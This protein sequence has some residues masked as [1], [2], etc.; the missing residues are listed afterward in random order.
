MT[1]SSPAL[2]VRTIPRAATAIGVT[3]LLALGAT[4][5]RP[6]PS[7]AASGVC[8]VDYTVSP[9]PGAYTAQIRVTNLGSPVSAWKLAWTYSSDEHVTAAWNAT[10]AQSGNAVTATNAAW[11]GDLPTGASVNFGVQGTGTANL[12]PG[13]FLFN[14]VSCDEPGGPGDPNTSGSPTPTDQPSGPPPADCGAAVVCSGFEDQSGPVPTGTWQVLS[15][16]CHGDGTASIDTSVAHG[17]TRSLRI[18]GRA[19][20][21]NHVF[22]ATTTDI[23]GIA[24]V[25]YARLWVRHTTA[26]PSSHVAAITLADAHDG[27]KDLRIG[28]QNGVLQWNRQSDDA[29][30]PVQSP[31]GV[32]QSRP[33]PT[34]KWVCLRFRIDTTKQS[35]D[36]Y[37][38]DVEVPG[39]HLDGVPTQDIDSQWLNRTTPPRPTTLRLGW[40]SYGGGDDTL[41]YD[42]VAVGPQPIGC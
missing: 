35:A 31:A 30:L 39:L 18:D 11:N 1:T 22:A 17:G 8:A 29:T 16:D 33:L 25:L 3:V 36:T 23:S 21:C 19:G 42:D 34:G 13:H 27:G 15:P 26:L 12:P 4:L 9:S 6:S 14:G 38:D 32:A 28:G 2:R 20:Y 41:W 5:T 10:V 24:P 40:E 37:V 7:E